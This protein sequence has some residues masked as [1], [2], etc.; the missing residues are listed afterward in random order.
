MESHFHSLAWDFRYALRNLCK[1]RRFSLIAIVALALGIGASTVV[2]SVVYNVFF[3]A[4]SYKNFDRSVVF[5]I[6]NTGNVG[7]SKGRAYFSPE[8]FRAFREQNHVFDDMI[9]HR[10]LGRLFYDDGKFTRVLPRGEVVSTNTFDYFGVPPLL[11]RTILEEDGRP[12]APPVFVMNYRLWQ[13]EFRGDPHIL[14]KTFIL[15]DTP[16][17]LVGIMPAFFNAFGASLW[18]PMRA[19]D[20]GNLIGRLKP[21]VSVEAAGAELDAIAHSL[22]KTSPRGTFPENFSVVSQTLLG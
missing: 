20:A 15:R 8:E 2:F 5:E 18:M 16:R 1:N 17:T 13:R 14:G 11:G 3:H 12:G 4:L 9:A 19:D 22:Q 21:G 7:A 10:V 6:R